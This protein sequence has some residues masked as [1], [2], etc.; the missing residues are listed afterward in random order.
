MAELPQNWIETELVNI[1]NLYT[2]N[3]INESVKKE[4]Y[5]N[6]SEGFNYIATKDI[7]YDK[8][9]NYK[10]GIK[11]PFEETSFKIAPK[12][13]VLLCIEG[14]SA[15]RKLAFTNEDVCFVNK[16]CAFVSRIS[17]EHAKFIYYYFQ[18]NDFKAI[19]NENKNGLIGGVSLNKLKQIKIIQPPLNEQKRIVEKLD[20]M[21][22]IVDNVNARLDKIPTALKRA[23]QSILNQAITGELTKDWREKNAYS[24]A[25]ELIL[26]LEIEKN[27]IYAKECEIAKS[28]ETKK[29]QKPKYFRIANNVLDINIPNQWSFINLSQTIYDFKYGTSTKSDYSYKGIPVIRIPNISNMKLSFDDLKYLN[30]SD[31]DSSNKIK[32]DDILIVRS[33]GSRDLVGKNALVKELDKEYAFASYL[34]RMRPLINNPEYLIL[35]LNTDAIKEQ[36]FSK[37]KSSAGINNINTE[38]LATTIIPLPPLEEQAEIVRRVKLAFEKLDKIELRYQKAKEYFDKLAQSILN[39]AFRGELVPQDPNDKPISLDDIQVQIAEKPSKKRKTLKNNK[40]QEMAKEIIEILKEYPEG[41]SPE[42]LFKNSKYSQK[43]FTDDDIIEF[44]K[45]LSNLLDLKLTEEKDS[46]NHKI[47]IKKVK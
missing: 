43:D 34:I 47:L 10:N 28:N 26:K 4:K 16:L 41:I 32:K 14:G 20:K 6:L 23:R 42:E 12:G 30:L 40:V 15:G 5:T 29:P 8:S 36:F 17:T 18:S 13:S 44:Y 24:S 27:N 35:L 19:F 22:R 9:I 38:E 7:G 21:M 45:E 31:I 3:S 37:A 39:K 2:G 46:V 25:K 11:I 33:N 1:T